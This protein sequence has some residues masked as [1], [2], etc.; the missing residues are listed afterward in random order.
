MK[1]V[2]R[3]AK[4]PA[5]L[6]RFEITPA[7]SRANLSN[8]KKFVTAG[9]R[10]LDAGKPTFMFVYLE[11]NPGTRGQR[12]NAQMVGGPPWDSEF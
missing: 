12:S 5:A 8:F 2:R 10:R 1:P 4:K 3:L 7:M 9:L 6:R 11:E